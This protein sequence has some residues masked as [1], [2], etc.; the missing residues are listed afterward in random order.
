MNIADPAANIEQVKTGKVA[1]PFSQNASDIL[2][3]SPGKEV[4]LQPRKRDRGVYHRIVAPVIAVESGL[5]VSTL[6]FRVAFGSVDR[7]HKKAF[8]GISPPGGGKALELIA[9]F[10]GV[11][12]H[13]VAA[14]RLSQA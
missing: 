14:S 5:H 10:S 11:A 1:K 2:S 8:W 4:D 12:D 7:K 9:N 13:L 6:W 3:I